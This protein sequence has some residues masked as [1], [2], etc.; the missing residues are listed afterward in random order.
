MLTGLIYDTLGTYLPALQGMLAIY[1][2]STEGVW[3]I[4][5]RKVRP[6][7]HPPKVP[8]DAGT[9]GPPFSKKKE[10]PG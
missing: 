9:A 2:I 6:F 7:G 3:I 8:A 10:L 4:S 5:P 1:V